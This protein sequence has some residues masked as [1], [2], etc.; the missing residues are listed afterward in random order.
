FAGT[1][2]LICLDKLC[3]ASLL[4]AARAS[5]AEVRIYPHLGYEKLER[6][7]ARHGTRRASIAAPAA[8]IAR[9]PRTVIVT[10]SVFSMDGDVADRY[11]ALPVVDEAPGTG[12]L[13]ATGAGLAERQGVAHRIPVTISTASKAL[14]GLGGIVTGRREVIETLVNR[15]RPFI[16]ST[17][18][19]A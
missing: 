10:D 2:D 1:G 13:G 17:G 5:G 3:H 8:A 7:L 6:L 12:R 15:A 19:P 11:A 16:Y 14:G 9:P 18:V 4:D